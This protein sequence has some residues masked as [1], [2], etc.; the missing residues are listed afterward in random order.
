M[1]SRRKV[2]LVSG[3]AG[4]A[5]VARAETPRL[6]EIVLTC[7]HVLPAT[8]PTHT[9]ALE[10]ARAISDESRGRVRV[11]VFAG[12]QLGSDVE[13]LQK[14]R[15]GS[16]DLL[17][18]SPLVLGS[19]LP[20]AQIS[21]VAF[22]FGDFF[23]DYRSIWAA[24]DGKLGEWVRRQVAKTELFAFEKMWDNGY[25]QMTSRDRQIVRPSDLKGF[26]MR[27]AVSPIFTSV[28]QHLKAVPVQV[29]F[30]AV[31]AALREK[32]VDGMENSMSLL[33]S[34]KIYEVQ[35]YCAIT[36]HIWDGF[37][38][39]GNQKNFSK[40]PADLQK[41]VI[42]NVNDSGVAQRAEVRKLNDSIARKLV[43]QGML[44][45]LTNAEEFRG[46]LRTAGYYAEWQKTF[47][48][49]SWELLEH[50]SGKLAI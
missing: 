17:S 42:R 50:H 32:R 31:Q 15:D 46:A 4:I 27:V 23:G 40:L 47:G 26:R 33:H 24:M 34:A 37:W 29:N 25:R 16:L 19:W 5:T 6:K 14:L 44:F 30:T 3:A 8:H 1:L 12:G 10:M 41:V 13:Q 11:D 38:M 49:E 35:K 7:G 20:A 21:G 43:E 2:L 48:L 22:A 18:L 9:R 45:S 28:F 39:L 36:N